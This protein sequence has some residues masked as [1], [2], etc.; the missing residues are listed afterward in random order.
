[1]H[2][3]SPFTHAGEFSFDAESL[4]HQ[5]NALHAGDR[6]PLPKDDKELDAW[7]HFH[8]GAFQKAYE[9]GLQCGPAGLNVAHKSACMYAAYIE[10]REKD[11]QDL[12]LEV[13]DRAAAQAK[14][15]PELPGAHYWQAYALGR[16]SQGVSVAKALAQGIGSRVKHALETTIQLEPRHAE[17]HI[18]LGVF[19]AEVID[20]VGILIGN[21][22]YG[23]RKETSLK[24]FQQGLLLTP[25]SPIAMMEYANSLVMLEGDKRMEDAT[26]LYEKA[27][28]I[29]PLDAKERLEVDMARAELAG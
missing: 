2:N 3:W 21:M 1:M 8:N 27:V 9:A 25:K 6:E 10:P 7:A 14:A 5:W 19:H 29:Q 15:H 16:Y 26:R 11:K 12:Y 13:S 28:A 20:K 23:A 17:A 22:T 24:L 4:R 18:A